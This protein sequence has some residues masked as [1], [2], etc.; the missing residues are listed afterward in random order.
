[1]KLLSEYGFGMDEIRRVIVNSN[2]LYIFHT[3]ITKRIS[4]ITVVASYEE[5]NTELNMSEE[6]YI[7]IKYYYTNNAYTPNILF[8]YT[9]PDYINI[10]LCYILI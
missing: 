7:N 6:K 9:I 3:I 8:I 10:T 4:T 2:E 5:L 1:M